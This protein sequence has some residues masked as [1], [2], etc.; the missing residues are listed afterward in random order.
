[1]CKPSTRSGDIDQTIESSVVMASI[2]GRVSARMRT[3]KWEPA[4]AGESSAEPEPTIKQPRQRRTAM[5]GG[6]W[7]R[8]TAARGL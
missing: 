4:K 7:R 5:D 6:A 2:N 8:R 3:T 1:V